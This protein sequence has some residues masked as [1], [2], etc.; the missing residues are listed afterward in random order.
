MLTVAMDANF[1]L[2]SKIRGTGALDTTL[3]PG[4]AYFVDNQ[5]YADFIK[6][7]VDAVDVRIASSTIERYMLMNSVS[8]RVMCGLPGPSQHAHQE[9][10]GA[11]CNWHG[12]SQ[13]CTAP[14]LPAI[15]GRRL[16]E[17]GT[18]RHYQF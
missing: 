6:D 12:S 8:G 13:L 9:I 11:S 18:V 7:Y 15:G 14:I 5:P 4:W 17:G 10:E 2:R 16:T 1:R 3:N